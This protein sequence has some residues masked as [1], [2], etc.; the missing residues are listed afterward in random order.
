MI[1]KY[2]YLV[3]YVTH[4]VYSTRVIDIFFISCTQVISMLY[5]IVLT[6]TICYNPRDLDFKELPEYASLCLLSLTV[7]SF[8][9]STICWFSMRLKFTSIFQ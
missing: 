8:D 9:N 2:Y 6:G 3:L 5:Q 4:V 1:N 7:Y